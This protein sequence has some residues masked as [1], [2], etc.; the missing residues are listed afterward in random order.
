[1]AAASRDHRPWGAVA[2]KR[3]LGAVAAG[4]AGTGDVGDVGELGGR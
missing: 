3:T 4:E 1:M 2:I